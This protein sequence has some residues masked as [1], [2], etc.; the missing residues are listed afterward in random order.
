M[1]NKYISKIIHNKDISSTMQN[2]T[3]ITCSKR[4][5]IDRIFSN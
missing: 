5:Y 2:K 4:Y 1:Y 3:E